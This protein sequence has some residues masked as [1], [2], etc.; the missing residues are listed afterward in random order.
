M[1]FI[2]TEA[3]IYRTAGN[4]LAPVSAEE[5]AAANYPI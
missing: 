5:C 4:G 2:V 1:D 3:G